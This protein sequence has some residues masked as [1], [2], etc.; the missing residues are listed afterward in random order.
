MIK[1]LGTQILGI[2]FG[3]F[4]AYYTFLHYKR[5]EIDLKEYLFWI[6]LWI[7]FIILTVFP[8]LTKPFIGSIGF[9]R[10]MDFFIAVGFMFLIVGIFYVYLITK[11]NQKRLEEVVKKIALNKKI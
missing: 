4:M 11:K 5:K 3:L 1:I 9:I 6:I 10:V 8:W 7:L 2:L